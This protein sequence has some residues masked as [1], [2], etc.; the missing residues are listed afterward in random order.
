MGCQTHNIAVDSF[1]LYI[2]ESC[3]QS[4]CCWY[5]DPLLVRLI[6][7]VWQCGPQ[8]SLLS[9]L[10]GE[11]YSKL[12]WSHS[13]LCFG[14]YSG[15]VLNIG[16]AAERIEAEEGTRGDEKTILVRY[17]VFHWFQS[18]F[19]TSPLQFCLENKTTVFP[20]PAGVVITTKNVRMYVALLN[21]IFCIAVLSWELPNMASSF[22]ISLFFH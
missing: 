7:P 18:V 16:I 2:R 11:A 9:V 21:H 4:S 5:C 3:E 20:S 17:T 8:H 14:L 13:L 15:H 1:V 10:P 19:F 6:S 12:V 22:Q